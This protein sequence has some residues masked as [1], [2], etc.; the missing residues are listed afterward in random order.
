DGRAISGDIHT[1]HAHEAVLEGG[2]KIDRV[3]RLPSA[4]VDACC[5]V[6]GLICRPYRQKP[7]T[8]ARIWSR[9]RWGFDPPPQ[10]ATQVKPIESPTITANL[11]CRRRTIAGL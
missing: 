7:M 9:S 10:P 8:T 3:A 5:F 11:A 1:D 4:A 6:A 2:A